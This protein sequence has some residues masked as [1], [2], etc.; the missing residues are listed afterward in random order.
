MLEWVAATVG[1][2]GVGIIASI[3]AGAEL[4]ITEDLVRL[5]D[6]R[7]LLLS[8][9]LGDAHLGRL[10]RMIELRG[11]APS[12]LNLA[13][14]GIIFDTEDLVVVLGF[15]TLESDLGLVDDGFDLFLK[16]GAKLGGLLEGLDS[17]LVQLTFQLSLAL[18]QETPEGVG[19]E[20]ERFFAVLSDVLVV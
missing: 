12:S 2:L 5:V 8:R 9:L 19:V 3:E 11:P 4:R 14:V 18:V 20:S 10:V 17:G 7:H 15:A 1:L 6:R 16:I 13:L